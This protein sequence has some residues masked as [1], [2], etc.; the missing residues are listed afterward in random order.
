T[1]GVGTPIRDLTQ[2]LCMTKKGR[3]VRSSRVDLAQPNVMLREIDYIL[4]RAEQFESR[5]VTLDQLVFFSTVTGDAWMLDP[6][7]GLALR[8][9][10]AGE[11]RP[12]RIVET[13]TR[14]GIEW[15]ASYSLDGDAFVKT[16]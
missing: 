8:L 9:A 3:T 4:R 13:A 14:Y 6:E 5:V 2:V 10:E 1:F 11:R 12:A 15:T 16:D 7:D